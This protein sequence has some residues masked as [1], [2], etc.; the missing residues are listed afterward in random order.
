MTGKMVN[1]VEGGMACVACGREVKYGVW[2]PF[3]SMY[4]GEMVC[5]ECVI[6]FCDGK[7]REARRERGANGDIKNEN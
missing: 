3:G 1:R 5:A 4:D 7:I 2:M 6:D